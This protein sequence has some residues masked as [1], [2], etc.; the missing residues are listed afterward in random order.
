METRRARWTRERYPS[1][2]IKRN[3]IV[4]IGADQFRTKGATVSRP[5]VTA[6]DNFVNELMTAWAGAPIYVDASAVPHSIGSN[7]IIDIATSAR[8]KGAYVIPSTQLDA[9]PAYQAAVQTVVQR[10]QRGVGLRVDLQEFA[11]AATWVR[12]WPSPLPSTDLIVDFADNVAIVQSL[13]SA[14]DTAF[15]Q[16]HQGPRWRSVTMSGSNMPG[17]FGGYTQGPH[18]LPRVELQL[19]RHLST[20]GLPYTLEY[21]DYT[22]VSPNA[23]PQG[24][25]WGFPINVRYSL[26]QNFLI[27]RGVGTTGFGGVDMDQQLLGHAQS[28]VAFPGR[29]PL[30]H[31]WADL[32]I[33][34]VANGVETTGNL[35]S[36]VQIGVNRHIE[37][38]RQLLP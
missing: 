10:D 4:V 8:A 1:G 6:A 27:C 36:W 31:C 30:A 5:A 3:T 12:S 23:P 38:T 35:E 14:L 16:L 32:R 17:N 11:N 20:I 34:H 33:D 9:P 26:D 28:I 19:W 37:L 2:P 21:G 29:G 18:L 25:A 15:L 13:G 24:I 7:P 22:S